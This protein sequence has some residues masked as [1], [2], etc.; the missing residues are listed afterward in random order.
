[1]TAPSAVTDPRP[2]PCEQTRRFD[3]ER[4][5]RQ[6]RRR[7][8]LLVLLALREPLLGRRLRLD[9]GE[10]EQHLFGIGE[11][12]LWILRERTRD[13]ALEARRNVV[14]QRAQ[15]TRRTMNCE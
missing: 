4:R 2:Q 1:M 5:D 8:V 6:R 3:V 12:A 14:A 7:L 11:P 15:R 13:H 10:R 9:V